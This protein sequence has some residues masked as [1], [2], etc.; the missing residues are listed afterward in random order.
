[1][2]IRVCVA[3]NQKVIAEGVA[4]MLRTNA[5]IEVVGVCDSHH[6][7]LSQIEVLM[8]DVIVIGSSS[9]D[10]NGNDLYELI[11]SH[12]AT[13]H[14]VVISSGIS[15]ISISEALKAGA[16]AHVSMNSD[17]EDLMAAIRLAAVGSSYLCRGSMHELTRDM[18]EPL[19]KSVTIKPELGAREAQ[20][21]RLVAVGRTSKEIA[22][23]LAI[24]PST[25]EVHRRNIMRKLG[26][27]KVA[28]LTRF[29]IRHQ[30]IVV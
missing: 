15:R 7:E 5:D 30:M 18:N 11:A 19:S 1:M 8:P 21:L 26:L 25:V 27:H 23:N 16:K 13:N 14:F 29:A 12:S 4:A 20:V 9:V 24:S 10:K 17:I 22:R 6:F 2:P 3:Y 28:D